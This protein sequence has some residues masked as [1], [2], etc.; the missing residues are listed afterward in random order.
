[1]SSRNGF[2][3]LVMKEDGTYIKLYPQQ[4][5]GECIQV[6]DIMDYLNDVKISDYDLL[7]IKNAVEHL[8]K[9]T[10]VKIAS[11]MLSPISENLIITISDDQLEAVAR[12]YP[13]S[14]HGKMLSA[15]G[16]ID[17]LKH[18]GVKYG[19]LKE[20][21]QSFLN[22]RVYSTNVTLAKG[23]PVR[24]GTSASV[25]YHFNT[26]ND[27]K[28][29]INEDGTVD[30]H[31]LNNISHI[32]EGD[33]LATLTPA[34]F[35]DDGM[36]VLGNPIKPLKV[37]N[38]ILK[39]GKNIHLSEDGLQM[40]SDVSGHV[41]LT[42]DK[43]FVSNTYEVLADVDTSTGDIDYDGN[44]SI[45]GNVRTGFTVTATGDIYVNGVVEGAKLL[46][47]GQVVLRCG[48][49]GMNR[50]EIRCEGDLITK[51][52]EN[53]TVVSGG[54]I[55]TDA[56]LHS[57]VLAKKDIIASG[58]RGLIVG[59]SVK[60]G[61]VID[62]KTGGSLMGTN[63]ELEVGIDPTVIQEYESIKNQIPELNKEK[64][65]LEQII[66][67]MKAKL[68]KGEQL[69]ADKI[70]MLRAVKPQYEGIREKIKNHLERLEE[71]NTV[72][73]NNQKGKI[74][75]NNM[76]YSGVKMIFGNESRFVHTN[77]QYCYFV[78]EGADIV[79]KG[80]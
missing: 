45:K 50:G 55:S 30:F 75:V 23:K 18:A 67:L 42:D 62:L 9:V 43:V 46:A 39:H 69:P 52:I 37:R 35:G 41:T 25:E 20:A 74:I 79:S 48:M 10:E 59:G 4:D 68:Q 47:G 27:T 13:P 63:T 19:I 2:F 54:S 33:L 17:T 14:N 57:K 1:M 65:K 66:L 6:S 70:Q 51:F 44:V 24:Q 60:S 78:K 73:L 32:A 53:A 77:E 58:K 12:F 3:H 22:N 38:T 8:Q 49:Q 11:A 7:A 29:Q 71:L 40:F 34:D 61:S 5:S 76:L 80:L 26:S 15:E 56:I 36:T 31:N 28:P 16:I 64:A 72:I 21:I